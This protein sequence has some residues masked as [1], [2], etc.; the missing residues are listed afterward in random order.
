M[1]GEFSTGSVGRGYCLLMD[2]GWRCCSYFM[3]CDSSMR[4][5]YPAPNAN[6]IKVEKAY[7]IR[8]N[9]EIGTERRKGEMTMIKEVKS[10]F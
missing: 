8:Q 2:S 1:S 6:N 7:V 10:R 4:E 5:T 9:T 3:M